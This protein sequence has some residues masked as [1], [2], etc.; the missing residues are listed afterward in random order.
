MMSKFFLG[1]LLLLFLLSCSSCRDEAISFD[2]DFH[3]G[4][5]KHNGII[6]QNGYLVKCD[7]L[8]I[9]RFGCMHEDKIIELI[10]ILHNARI[11]R[12]DKKR[13]MKILDEVL[14]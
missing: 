10:G 2:P 7:T 1:L 4:S 6:S 9:E 5:Q 12:K 14:D 13:M 3:V 8:Q 11:P